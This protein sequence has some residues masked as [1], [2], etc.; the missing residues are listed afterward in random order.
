MAKKME[1]FRA[2][3]AALAMFL[4]IA[5]GDL[6]PVPQQTTIVQEMLDDA[7]MC[8]DWMPFLKSDSMKE[9]DVPILEANQ[10]ITS[11]EFSK[12]L[13]YGIHDSMCNICQLSAINAKFQNKTIFSEDVQKNLADNEAQVSFCSFLKYLINLQFFTE[14]IWINYNLLWI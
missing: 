12:F 8:K 2:Y 4:M 5:P 13:C 11:N 1:S 14:R 6:N 9:C 3:A 7:N 10:K